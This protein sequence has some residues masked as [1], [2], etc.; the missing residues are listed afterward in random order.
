MSGTP[1]TLS[2][3]VASVTQQTVAMQ[4]G[5]VGSNGSPAANG[6]GTLDLSSSVGQA[7]PPSSSTSA[8]DLGT[9]PLKTK[10]NVEI[11]GFPLG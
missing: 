8:D 5:G 10:R 1:S 3:A 6:I 9:P 11:P 2:T 4:A 7:I